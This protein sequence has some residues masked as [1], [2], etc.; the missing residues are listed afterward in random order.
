M[1]VAPTQILGQYIFSEIASVQWRISRDDRSKSELP[2][3][4]QFMEPRIPATHGSIA[5][6][7]WL[8]QGL[9]GYDRNIPI[10][11]EIDLLERLRM[12]GDVLVVT[13]PSV[14]GV[15]TSNTQAEDNIQDLAPELR[16][17]G[18]EELLSRARELCNARLEE[19]RL[20]CNVSAESSGS[21]APPRH[22]LT[23][24]KVQVIE[25]EALPD[26]DVPDHNLDNSDF[27]RGAETPIEAA[28]RFLVS[29]GPRIIAALTSWRSHRKMEAYTLP[30]S[31][32]KKVGGKTPTVEAGGERPAVVSVPD[33]APTVEVGGETPTVEVGG[34]TPAPKKTPRRR[35]QPHA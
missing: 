23:S 10:P 6:P 21:S 30:D 12:V 3:A 31:I 20:D 1:P 16:N 13:D 2:L 7:S 5:L 24:L 14:V 17:L 27:L 26:D 29:Q 19:D 33:Q 28:T 25:L 34:E 22:V 32:P 9:G 4:M 15:V 35:H 8:F 18:Y 11:Y